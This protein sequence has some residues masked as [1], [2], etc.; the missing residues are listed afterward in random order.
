MT[1]SWTWK[2]RRKLSKKGRGSYR[3][4]KNAIAQNPVRTAIWPIT[5]GVQWEMR[6]EA[7]KDQSKGG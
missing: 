1:L 6:Q 7:G 4:G 3:G 2:D 5:G